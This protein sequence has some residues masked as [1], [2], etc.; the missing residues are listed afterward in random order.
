M[1]AKLRTAWRVV[2]SE[3]RTLREKHGMEKRSKEMN[4]QQFRNLT[5]AFAVAA[6][7]NFTI[8]EHPTVFKLVADASAAGRS[9]GM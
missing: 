2:Q 8:F 4:N 3:R 6:L 1:A 7:I 5:G 9:I